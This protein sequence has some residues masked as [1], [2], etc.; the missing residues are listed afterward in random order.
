MKKVLMILGGLCLAAI[1]V[2]GA[3]FVYMTVVGPGLD[4]ESKAYVMESV[5]VICSSFDE[6]TFRKA[7]SPELLKAASPE[8][9]TK[10]LIWFKRLGRFDRVVE[11]KGDSNI[12]FMLGS[13]KSITAKYWAKVEFETG[14]ATIQIVL[15]KREDGWKYRLFTINSMALMPGPAPAPPAS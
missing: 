15:V 3:F 6:Q 4:Q 5:P 1:V 13:G 8:E 11:V 10:I 14:P 9:L 12:S 7:A 2:I